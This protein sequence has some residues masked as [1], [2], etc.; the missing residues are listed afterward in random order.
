ME[1][2][3]KAQTPHAGYA[4]DPSCLSVQVVGKDLQSIFEFKSFNRMQ[5]ACFDLLFK[6]DEN[7]VITGTSSATF[8]Q[9]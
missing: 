4:A 7:A 1:E 6:T 9:L 3:H 8:C 5:T 2:P